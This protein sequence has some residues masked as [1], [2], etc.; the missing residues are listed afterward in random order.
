MILR[1]MFRNIIKFDSTHLN[2]QDFVIFVV[3]I[4]RYRKPNCGLLKI[5]LFKTFIVKQ[6]RLY[7]LCRWLVFRLAC[8][9]FKNYFKYLFIL[10]YSFI[11]TAAISLHQLLNVLLET[12]TL[13]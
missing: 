3:N 9:I 2:N 13:N 4:R 6:E 8:G 5:T 1:K 12:K 10:N 7:L 11:F